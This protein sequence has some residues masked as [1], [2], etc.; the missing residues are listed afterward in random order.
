MTLEKFGEKVRRERKQQGLSQQELSDGCGI[1]RTY[2]SQI[3]HGKAKNLSLET[4]ERLRTKLGI[5]GPF[6]ET[7]PHRKD[8]IPDSL[9]K[10]AE[11]EGIP[12]QDLKMLATIGYRGKQPSSPEMWRVVYDVIR[13]ATVGAG[14]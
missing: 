13:S 7:S 2:L 1:S 14:T 12:K 5:D 9:K 4:A 11:D 8:T 10:F 3:E 6:Q